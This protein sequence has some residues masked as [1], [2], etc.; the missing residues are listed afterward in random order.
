MKPEKETLSSN[1]CETPFR[2]LTPFLFFVLTFVI[3]LPL[4]FWSDVPQRDVAARYIPMVDAFASGDF[5][6]AF[7]PRTGFC[8]TVFAG[9]LAWLFHF[10]GFTAVKLSSLFFMALAVFP[11]YGL[12]RRIYSERVAV[13][14]LL[15]YVL[16]SQVMRLAYSGLRDSCKVF[17]ILLAAYGLIVIFQERRKLSG[18]LLLALAAAGGILTRGDLLGFMTALFFWGIVLEYAL[19]PRFPWRSLCGAALAFILCLPAIL[20][21]EWTVG[22]AVPEMRFAVIFEKGFGRAPMTSDTILLFAAG[23][24]LL[25][26]LALAA[27]KL[28][29]HK[30]SAKIAM[31]FA[32]V[33]LTG[34][35]A[36]TVFSKEFLAKGLVFD[37]LD[38]VLK[39]FFPVMAVF[40]IVGIVF[41]IRRKEWRKE[42]SILAALLIG[43]NVMLILQIFFFDKY[44]YVAIRY[45]LPAV[46]LELPWAVL[47]L[48][49]IRRLLLCKVSGP[50]TRIALTA[51]LLSLLGTLLL[52]DLARPSLGCCAKK[53]EILEKKAIRQVAEIIRNDYRGPAKSKP[54]REFKSYT[55]GNLP[56]ICYVI[57]VQ[58]KKN[59]RLDEGKITLS[60]YF[61]GGRA[62]DSALDAEY[63]VVRS[64]KSEPEALRIFDNYES[65]G[66]IE[67]QKKNYTIWKPKNRP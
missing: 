2:R 56:R 32:A 16:A 31:A 13:F 55:S 15:T 22:A 58:E 38:G 59:L 49:E 18:Y 12:T 47:G 9:I 48:M 3:C 6:Y 5:L 21:H 19:L 63:I 8:H 11:L 23:L 57:Y 41:R 26:L 39:G 36:F 17:F 20:L 4:V 42:D 35:L 45:L 24:V 33:L 25:F 34:T 10:D 54:P 65:L 51:V 62:V 7:H 37:F 67:L 53:K 30:Y 14:T 60:A 40:A 1:G 28:T 46:P 66:T 64:E 29:G 44:L 61:S 50:R 43:H 52:F 27:R